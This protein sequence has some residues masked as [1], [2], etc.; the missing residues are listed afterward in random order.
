M[1]PVSERL[2]ALELSA[3][4]LALVEAA[5]HAYLDDFGHDQADLLRE[6]KALL[7][8]LPPASGAPDPRV[9]GQ[10]SVSEL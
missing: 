9:S 1:G 10:S 5:L 2:I 4:E 3:S 8:K 7:A 6:L